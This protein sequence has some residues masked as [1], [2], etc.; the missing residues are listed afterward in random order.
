MESDGDVVVVPLRRRIPDTAPVELFTIKD[1]A[2]ACGLPQP[3][4]SQLVPH[5]DTAAGRLYTA[6]QM[7][8]AVDLADEIRTRNRRASSP[9]EGPRGLHIA[10]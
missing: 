10:R 3:V 4:I 5:T 2:Q 8:C 7:R 9:L 6:E 1:V